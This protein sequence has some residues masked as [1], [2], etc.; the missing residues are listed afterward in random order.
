MRRAS[1]LVKIP[2]LPFG[3]PDHGQILAELSE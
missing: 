2:G 1:I 3:N